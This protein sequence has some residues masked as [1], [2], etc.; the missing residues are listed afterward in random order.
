MGVVYFS[1]RID[2]TLRGGIGTEINAMLDV[3]GGDAVAVVV[4]SMPQSRRIV[5]GGYSVIDGV[6]LP[7]TP[8]AQDVRTPVHECSVPRLLE[9]QTGC[10]IG[11]LPLGTVLKGRGCIAEEL[12]R[13]RTLGYQVIVVDAITLEDIEEIA[14][15]C[16]SLDWNVLAVDPGAFTAK[17]AYCRGLTSPE[18]PNVPEKTADGTGKTVLIAAGSATPVTKK[19]MAVLCQDPRH[20]QVSVNPV[21]LIDG[22]RS[23]E[24]EVERAV[25]QIMALLEQTV[26]PRAILIETALHN[27]ILD[28]SQEDRKR[29]YA[30]GM[31]A[32][33]INGGLG[34]I[35]QMVLEQAGRDRIAGLYT[36][37]G[38]TMVS[39]CFQL[40]TEC[41]EMLDYVIAQTD[42]GRMCGK[43][44]GMPIIGKGGLTGHDTI[45]PEIVDRL[46]RE[47]AR[48]Y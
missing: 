5:V 32:D 10:K 37:G 8:V 30:N 18:A 25:G 13:Q 21:P 7:N 28:L 33:R 41:L 47:A 12:A 17:L 29:G 16:V 20:L 34:A 4:P 2:T 6:A 35:V 26:P 43:Y 19:Q 45:V 40:G 11:L 36:T 39:I 3:M 46:F 42:V 1:K 14:A 38:D 31:S 27:D 23:A 24:K 44:Q 22:S 15:A 9:E 48:T